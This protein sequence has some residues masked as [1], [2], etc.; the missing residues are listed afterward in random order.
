MRTNNKYSGVCGPISLASSDGAMSGDDGDLVHD[1]AELILFGL[2]V[3][4]RPPECIFIVRWKGARTK[5]PGR[6]L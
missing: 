4:G 5:R 2:Y 3:S 1:R 6:R